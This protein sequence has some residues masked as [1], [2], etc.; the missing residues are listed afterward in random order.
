M[1]S[2]PA[3]GTRRRDHSEE[4]TAAVGLR[5]GVYRDRL[6]E[7]LFGPTLRVML[8]RVVRLASFFF[9]GEKIAWQLIVVVVPP[10]P[11]ASVPRAVR[12]YML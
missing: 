6:G 3:C 5:C 11:P 1:L 7:V 2:Y 12:R 8:D 4:S 9:P 10:S